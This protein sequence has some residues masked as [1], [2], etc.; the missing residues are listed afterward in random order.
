ML[1]DWFVS[2]LAGSGSLDYEVKDLFIPDGYWFSMPVPEVKRGG[3]RYLAP[4][5]L[6]PLSVHPALAMG[7]AQRALGIIAGTAAKKKRLTSTNTIADRGAFQRD[8]GYE[9]LRL[10]AARSYI[11][12]LLD[13]LGSTPWPEQPDP[14][15][16]AAELAGAGA[17]VTEVAVS[18]VQ[19]AYKYAGASAIRLDNPLQQILRDIQ[20]AQQHVIIADT[21]Y[22][23]LGQWAIAR[24]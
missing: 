17:Y 15:A 14:E 12:G 19:F 5:P 3:T 16:F 23:A 9:Y 20:V 4:V 18:V 8:L 11:V 2:G 24:T 13:E 10:S 6:G 21:S 7:A 22:D 1:D